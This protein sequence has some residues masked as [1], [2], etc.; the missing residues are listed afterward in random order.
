MMNVTDDDT[1]GEKPSKVLRTMLSKIE[2]IEQTLKKQ[3]K[4]IEE[5]RK[6]KEKAGNKFEVH[7][8][9]SNSYCT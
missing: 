6:V 5:I 1:K 2:Q 4:D 8:I 3:G 9:F 7:E